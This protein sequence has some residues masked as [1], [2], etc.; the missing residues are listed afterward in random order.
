M[1]S[2]LWIFKDIAAINEFHDLKLVD[3][4]PEQDVPNET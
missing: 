1:K 3:L 4:K 2:L